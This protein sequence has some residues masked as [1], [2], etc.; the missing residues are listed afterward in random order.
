MAAEADA[1]GDPAP[2]LAHWGLTGAVATR[3][4]SGLINETFLVQGAHGGRWI[5]QRV[6]TIFSPA[7][8]DDI[9]AATR[10]LESRGLTTPRLV[11]SGTGALYVTAGGRLWRLLT[12]VPGV[13][14]DRL[15]ERVQAREAGRLLARFHGALADFDRPFANPR[16]G[17]HDTPRH[18]ATL[19]EAVDRHRRHPR[20][21]RIAPLAE[22]IGALAERL[23][24]LPR[25]PDRVVHGDPK[26]SNFVFDEASG[27]A[28]CLIDLDTLTRMPLPLELGDALRSWCNPRGEDVA[29]ARFDLDLFE[30]AVAGY[31]GEACAI[32]APEWRC[33]VAATETILVELAARFCA[34]ALNERYFGWDRDRFAS[35][36]EHNELR[37]RGQ[38]ACARSLMR[39]RERAQALIARAFGGG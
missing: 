28:V 31:A 24:P 16:L 6:H 5:L 11:P 14:H 25:L 19:R 15:R 4:G 10:H 20:I 27:R 17:V 32:A 26:I 18:L 38:L 22:E 33:L 36:A 23:E 3:I 12:Y 9:D 29:D 30:A 37:A 1:H 39:Q 34:D 7:V 21:D 2:V 35:R 13:T 8:H